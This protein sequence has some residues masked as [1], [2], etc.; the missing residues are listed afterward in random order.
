MERNCEIN[1]PAGAKSI[2]GVRVKRH[3]SNDLHNEEKSIMKL[4]PEFSVKLERSPV[5]SFKISSLPKQNGS[6]AQGLSSTT[7][8]KK[9]F[10]STLRK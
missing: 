5:N 7:P 8:W 4:N 2:T 9:A 6:S 3:A 1:Y 10:T